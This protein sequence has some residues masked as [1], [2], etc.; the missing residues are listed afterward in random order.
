MTLLVAL[1]NFLVHL[2]AEHPFSHVL[3]GLL[4]G[5]VFGYEA[6]ELSVDEMPAELRRH[7]AKALRRAL[8]WI[9]ITA[10]TIT[11]VVYS[12]LPYVYPAD[13][14]RALK[15]QVKRISSDEQSL[16]EKKRAA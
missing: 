14:D 15:L 4:A 10:W 3:V 8:A 16:A 9:T 12:I 5:H 6:S 7:N 2:I 1:A 13:R 11:L